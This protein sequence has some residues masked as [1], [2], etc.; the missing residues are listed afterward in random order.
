M[1]RSIEEKTKD[2]AIV[3]YNLRRAVVLVTES[4]KVG[5]E[6]D[7]TPLAPTGPLTTGNLFNQLYEIL[8]STDE[9][10]LVEQPPLDIDINRPVLNVK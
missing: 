5:D 8:T 9:I 3:L 7:K 1:N 6:K 4:L 2:K 10:D